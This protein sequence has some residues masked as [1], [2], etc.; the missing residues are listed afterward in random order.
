MLLLKQNMRWQRTSQVNISHQKAYTWLK[1]YI[2]KNNMSSQATP[3]ILR[4]HSKVTENNS[5]D[6]NISQNLWWYHHP[7]YITIYRIKVAFQLCYNRNISQEMSLKCPLSVYLG[8]RWPPSKI[9]RWMFFMHLFLQWQ[10]HRS[11]D[12]DMAI[13][14][15]SKYLPHEIN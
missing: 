13:N 7:R 12:Y 2:V 6:A 1:K 14:G 11:R 15:D 4:I 3:Y 10:R 5:G 8:F 9:T